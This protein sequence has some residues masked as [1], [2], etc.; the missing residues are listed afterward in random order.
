MESELTGISKTIRDMFLKNVYH[1]NTDDYLFNGGPEWAKES[2]FEFKIRMTMRLIPWY[3]FGA[4]LLYK[5][6]K[7]MD[8]RKC[9]N[10]VPR[11]YEY[12][13]GIACFVCYSIQIYTKFNSQTMIFLLNPC[14]VYTLW[15]GYLLVTKYSKFNQL[16]F[17]FWFANVS[18][19]MIG[20]VFAENDELELVIEIYSYWIQHVIA[21][22][23]APLALIFSG[24][25]AHKTYVNPLTI[26][27][28]YQFF[29]IYMR[30]FLTPMSNWTWANLNHTLW[31]IDNDPWRTTFNLKEYYYFWAE[32]YLCLGAITG[33]SLVS[34]I[35]YLLYPSIFKVNEELAVKVKTK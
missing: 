19:P 17:L 6:V 24:R 3:I 26:I 33:A 13:L 8:Q 27:L 2:T 9:K 25:Y 16:V 23:I 11:W 5:F 29:T 22:F 18:S 20:M 34:G 35:A 1:G 10:V 28:G 30:F 7:T 4:Y 14:H 21:S 15:W 12:L 31:G 32:F